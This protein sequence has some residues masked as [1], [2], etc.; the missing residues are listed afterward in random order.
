LV[1]VL[2]LVKFTALQFFTSQE[3]S[4]MDDNLQVAPELFRQF[5]FE[6]RTAGDLLKQSPRCVPL[7][8]LHFYM[9]AYTALYI[10]TMLYHMCIH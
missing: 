4:V 1:D 9:T 10:D 8:L 6:D 3:T 5:E 2:D 7:I